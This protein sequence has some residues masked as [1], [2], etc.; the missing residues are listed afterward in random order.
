ML[1]TGQLVLLLLNARYSSFNMLLT[2][3]A[4][5]GVDGFFKFCSLRIWGKL[6]STDMPPSPL[7][8]SNKTI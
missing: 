2:H 5:G 6:T 4:G 8:G 3:Q 1:N 7:K